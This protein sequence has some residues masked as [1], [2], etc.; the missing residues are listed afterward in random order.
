MH[1][2]AFPIKLASKRSNP[3]QKR[4]L[5]DDDLQI[6]ADL[7]C[8]GLRE[9][10]YKEI[11][12]GRKRSEVV[13]FLRHLVTRCEIRQY[14]PTKKYFRKRAAALF[15][16]TVEG[17]VVGFS[18]LGQFVPKPAPNA[19]YF[20][21]DPDYDGG[22]DADHVPVIPRYSISSNAS[23]I[24]ESPLQ[25]PTPGEADKRSINNG[26]ELLMLGVVPLQRGLRYGASI[27]QSLIKECSSQYFNLIVRCPN[28]NQLLF[29]MLVV[30][31]FLAVGRYCQGRILRFRPSLPN[32][33]ASWSSRLSL[34][35]E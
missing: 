8:D 28:D 10:L 23:H 34:Y 29:G 17:S 27:L 22:T 31:G 21:H 9:G 11:V 12:P 20:P 6:V 19:S 13:Q 25:D 30:R 5:E 3:I 18:V 15:V 35:S 26:V 32:S 4:T 24:D 1:Q 33:S 7:I 2:L 16:Y 14:D